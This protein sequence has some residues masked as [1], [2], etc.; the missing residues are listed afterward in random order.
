[1]TANADI[2]GLSATYALGQPNL[3]T[4]GA[5]VADPFGNENT[6]NAGQGCTTTINGCGMSR[7]W[8]M[9]YDST[10]SRLFVS[11]PDNHRV[12]VW[13]LSGTITTGMIAFRVLGQTG[14]TTRTT[15]AANPTA[16]PGSVNGTPSACSMAFPTGLEYHAAT[17]RLFVSDSGNSRV[18]VFDMSAG[19][20]NGMAASRVLG[21]PNFTSGNAY[22]ASAAC[23]GSVNGTPSACSMS[24]P[25]HL[26]YDSTNGR[27]F[28]ADASARRV[29]VFSV[30][31]L[32][33]TVNGEAAINV[34]GQPNFTTVTEN[35]ACGGGSS[36]T[37]NG[38][39]LGSWGL[40]LAYDTVDS[41]LF[42][43]DSMNHR[44]LVWNAASLTN[45]STANFVLGKTNLT[46]GYNASDAEFGGDITRAALVAPMGIFYDAVGDRLWVADSGNHRI[47]EFG[48]N[49]GGTPIV[50]P[51]NPMSVDTVDNGNGT[52]TVTIVDDLG[53]S[54]SVTLPSGTT[55]IGG[56]DIT[57][58]IQDAGSD[59]PRIEISA[60]LPGAPGTSTK[61]VT[62]PV[63]SEE[64]FC[65]RDRADADYGDA[66]P[67]FGGDCMWCEWT[68]LPNPGQC[69]TFAARN[70]ASCSSGGTHNVQVCLSANGQTI[71]INNAWHTM[72][73]LGSDR[74]V[75][76]P[77]GDG[78]CGSARSTGVAGLLMIAGLLLSRR[79]RA[80]T[81]IPGVGK[82]R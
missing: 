79:R 63:D 17:N 60:D 43:S 38:C 54:Y 6:Q 45:G 73:Q 56:G 15:N 71:T 16:C 78:G 65:I 69:Q 39:G 74:S 21:Q 46:S 53:Q 18:L 5:N 50:V 22:T 62:L 31:T 32:A 70:T 35:T 82:R 36:G 23:V 33:N 4:G 20:T 12:L 80:P 37:V 68:N 14:F 81:R 75:M 19:I 11:D 67:L 57:L 52:Y 58:D 61:T 72:V 26:V 25:D 48:A 28:A 77:P 7:P 34:L 13:N 55:G 42:V 1:M 64:L 9:A 47:E 10:N 49:V 3:T 2:S 27:L 66:Y 59:N 29:L 24:E 44:V 51:G 76:V 8:A 41:R 30:S 40:G